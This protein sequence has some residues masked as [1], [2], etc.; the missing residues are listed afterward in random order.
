MDKIIDNDDLIAK[1]SRDLSPLENRRYRRLKSRLLSK[2]NLSSEKYHVSDEET[3]SS[4][5][6]DYAGTRAEDKHSY[7]NGPPVEKSCEKNT[8]FI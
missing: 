7:D 2:Y 5:I 8:Q 6:L 4:I 3:Q 1:R